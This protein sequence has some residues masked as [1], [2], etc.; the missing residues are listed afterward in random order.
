MWISGRFCA[1]RAVSCGSTRRPQAV[2]PHARVRRRVADGER[3]RLSPGLYLASGHRLTHEARVRAAWLWAGD[4]AL[5]SG[6]AAAYSH[7]ML[8]R[9]PDVVEVTVPRRHD[10]R[11]QPDVS[12]RRRDIAATDQVGLRD[13]LLTERALAVLETA[14]ALPDGSAFPDRALQ[15]FTGFDA[16]HRAHCRMIGGAGSPAAGRLL[17]AAADRSQ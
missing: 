10:P 14:V 13:I 11:A 6:P 2:S 5:V 7:G 1:A 3:Q 9:A 17:V 8:D 12:V 15:R 4:R 16:V